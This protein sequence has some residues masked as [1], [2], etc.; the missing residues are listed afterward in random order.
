M[1]SD[2]FVVPPLTWILFS[3][4]FQTS[5][6]GLDGSVKVAGRKMRS[7]GLSASILARALATLT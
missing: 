4:V 3:H 6:G 2:S 7:T 1:F 5:L